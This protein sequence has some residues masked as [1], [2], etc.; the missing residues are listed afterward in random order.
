[1]SHI[2]SAQTDVVHL[3]G[4]AGKCVREG[5]GRRSA[6]CHPREG[7]DLFQWDTRIG[8]EIPAFAGMTLAGHAYG[9]RDRP[10]ARWASI[11]V[12]KFRDAI[13]IKELTEN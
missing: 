1:M 10:S 3:E 8:Q 12:L 4:Y 11:A 9:V 6:L 13:L 2:R 5:H 7:G